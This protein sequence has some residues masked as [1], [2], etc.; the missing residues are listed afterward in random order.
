[1]PYPLFAFAALIPW[2]FFSNALGA[3]ANS[4]IGNTHLISKI[5]FPRLLISFSSLGTGLLD[6]AVALLVMFAMMAG[7][8]VAPGM[9]LFALPF[10]V[11]LT[12]AAACGVGSGLAALCAIYR[13]FRYV[14]PF[15]LQLWMFA[16]P[17][18]YPITMVPPRWRPLL[19]LNPLAGAIDGFRASLLGQPFNVPALATS[20]AVTLLAG[21]AGLMYFR[22]VER[23]VADLI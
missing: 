3:S 7:Y 23:R 17:V 8:G 10:L 14:V 6:L 15:A 11:V 1:V 12:A 20:A 22:R 13:D 2:T 4:L 9:R 18:I 19:Y 5:Y 16:S 21:W